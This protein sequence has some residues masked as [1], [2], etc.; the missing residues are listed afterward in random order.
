MSGAEMTVF[1]GGE[2]MVTLWGAYQKPDGYH[3]SAAVGL[4]TSISTGSRGWW[5]G[6]TR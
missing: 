3:E 4:E 6:Q 1:L 2:F 5:A